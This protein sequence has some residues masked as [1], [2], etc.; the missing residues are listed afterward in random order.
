MVHGR[1]SFMGPVVIQRE[2]ITGHGTTTI[3]FKVVSEFTQDATYPFNQCPASN[4]LRQQPFVLFWHK[5][6]VDASHGINASTSPLYNMICYSSGCQVACFYLL[7]K[8]LMSSL[9]MMVMARTTN[10]C[11]HIPCRH[12]ARFL[13]CASVPNCI[14]SANLP[15]FVIFD[16][17][18][19][20]TATSVRI[21]NAK[22]MTSSRFPN[23]Y[24]MTFPS[25][26]L[27]LLLLFGSILLCT[28]SNRNRV[29]NPFHRHR[30][31]SP[32]PPQ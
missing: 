5:H 1:E 2:L 29:I 16:F 31:G 19:P 12:R 22:T 10:P 13:S 3:N 15:F 30:P 25:K 24:S 27:R 18:R 7:S 4:L 26:I 14:L 6:R 8:Y 23:S 9:R 28:L 11:L 21:Y 32:A 17:E 20:L